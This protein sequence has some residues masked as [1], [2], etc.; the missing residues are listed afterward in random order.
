M[1]P[2]KKE[3]E[4]QSIDLKSNKLLLLLVRVFPLLV[5]KKKKKRMIENFNWSP[6]L[7]FV[8]LLKMFWER[9]S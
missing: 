7:S 2:K 5:W 4:N 8:G 3:K 6:A 9:P 1:Q